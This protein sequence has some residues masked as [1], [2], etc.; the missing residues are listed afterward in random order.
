MLKDGELKVHCMYYLR[1]SVGGNVEKNRGE[2]LYAAKLYE[3][4]PDLNKD[5]S[6]IQSR[7]VKLRDETRPIWS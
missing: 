6:S 3:T 4:Q 7:T 1:Q 2:C 5:D